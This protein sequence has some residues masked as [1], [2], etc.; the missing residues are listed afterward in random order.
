MVT[1]YLILP[2]RLMSYASFQFVASDF[3]KHTRESQKNYFNLLRGPPHD[4]V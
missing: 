2:F 4:H 3:E 1:M